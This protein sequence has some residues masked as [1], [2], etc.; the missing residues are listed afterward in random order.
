MSYKLRPG[1]DDPTPDSGEPNPSQYNRRKA[2][3]H[4]QGAISCAEHS[5]KHMQ[6]ALVRMEGELALGDHTDDQIDPTKAILDYLDV[7]Q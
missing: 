6:R 1:P 3:K 5:I 2:I 7:C 4:L